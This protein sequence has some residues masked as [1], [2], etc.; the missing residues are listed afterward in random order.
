MSA[1]QPRNVGLSFTRVTSIFPDVTPILFLIWHQYCSSYDTNIVPHMT[2]ILF[3]IWHQYCSSYDTNI[4]PHMTPILFLIWHKYCLV[5][6]R[7]AKSDSCFYH[8]RAKRNMYVFLKSI[9]DN[10]INH[11]PNVFSF[12]DFLSLRHKLKGQGLYWKCIYLNS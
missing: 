3:L 1:T 9:Y 12:I 10:K 7:K 5:Q 11:W 8:N 2:Q 4:V 6:E